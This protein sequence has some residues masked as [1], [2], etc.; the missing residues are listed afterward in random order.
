MPAAVAL[1]WQCW[2]LGDQPL[3]H[4]LLSLALDGMKDEDERVCPC[5]NCAASYDSASHFHFVFLD[6]RL[7][8]KR[9]AASI[10]SIRQALRIASLVYERPSKRSILVTDF[11]HGDFVDEH[12]VAFFDVVNMNLRIFFDLRSFDHSA[13]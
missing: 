12:V 5:R 13:I 10:I 3:G 9:L 1:A 6:C 11:R 8:T 7:K 2:Q 4:N